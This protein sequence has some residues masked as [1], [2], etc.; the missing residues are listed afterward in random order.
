MRQ[1]NSMDIQI[2]LTRT[3][4]NKLVKCLL[5]PTSWIYLRHGCFPSFEHSQVITKDALS[6]LD[7]FY[8]VGANVGQFS[9]Y[10]RC[11]GLTQSIVAF[12][13]LPISFSKLAGLSNIFTNCYLYNVA[14]GSSCCR[15]PIYIAEPSDSS[16][17]LPLSDLQTEYFNTKSAAITSTIEVRTLQDYLSIHPCTNGF[18]KIDVQGLELEV[19]KGVDKL[20]DFFEYVY[21]E[22][23]FV[24]LYKDQPLFTDILKFLDHHQFRLYGL[25]NPQSNKN[26]MIIQ[27]D[28]LF[29]RVSRHHSNPGCQ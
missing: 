2:N 13:P 26:R 28:C 14:I 25:Y 9:A 4:L 17:L 22:S 21:V 15:A 3:R 24:E 8:D 5:N 10:L 23:S 16:S 29:R 27:A 20:S 7:M 1:F 19:L 12:E 6:S 11:L 18:L